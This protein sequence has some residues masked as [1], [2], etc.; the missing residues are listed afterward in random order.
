MSS[1]SAGELASDNL[2]SQA[3]PGTEVIRVVLLYSGDSKMLL[4]TGAGVFWSPGLYDCLRGSCWQGLFFLV[5]LAL[6]F[7]VMAA[8]GFVLCCACLSCFL[9]MRHSCDNYVEA[10][11]LANDFCV[12]CSNVPCWR[13]W[14][15]WTMFDG[16][17][18]EPEHRASALRKIVHWCAR[19]I[20]L[21]TL[22]WVVSCVDHCDRTRKP[23]CASCASIYPVR[24]RVQE[25]PSSLARHSFNWLHNMFP[26]T[27]RYANSSRRMLLFARRSVIHSY[28]K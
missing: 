5:T 17:R 9:L 12:L 6:L 28:T 23:G 13:R 11:T 8:I 3:P 20:E 24:K 22:P 18:W 7:H 1:G 14:C 27:G 16:S 19:H 15:T 25:V 2:W 21:C 4:P 10:C 26:R